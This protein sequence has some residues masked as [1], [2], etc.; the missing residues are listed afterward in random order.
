MHPRIEVRE[1]VAELLGRVRE[2]EA[3]RHFWNGLGRF[4]RVGWDRVVRGIEARE[5]AAE[6]LDAG[7]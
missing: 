6:G 1:A 5:G 2:H 4:G 3:G 7:E